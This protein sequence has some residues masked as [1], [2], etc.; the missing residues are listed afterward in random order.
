[1]FSGED[2]LNNVKNFQNIETL[3]IMIFRVD[4]PVDPTIPAFI[5][6]IFFLIILFLWGSGDY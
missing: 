3:W 5:Y 2:I 6:I 4:S 1:L